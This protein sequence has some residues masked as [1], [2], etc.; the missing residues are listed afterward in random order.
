MPWVRTLAILVGDG[1]GD[2]V[3]DLV[4]VTV[5]VGFGVPVVAVGRAVF[6]AEIF[7]RVGLGATADGRVVGVALGVGVLVGEGGTLVGVG[8]GG[9]LV[10]MG[11]SAAARS[12]SA[13]AVGAAT[14]AGVGVPGSARGPVTGAG[15]EVGTVASLSPKTPQAASETETASTRPRPISLRTGSGALCHLATLHLPWPEPFH[16][17]TLAGSSRTAS[18][19]AAGKDS[20]CHTVAMHSD[21]FLT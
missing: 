8:G 9:V 17:G 11:V 5:A 16:G 2:E 6:V 12:G 13:V 14:S 19:P 1:V 21:A 7:V 10:A 20:T 15:V 4:A 18:L 3:G